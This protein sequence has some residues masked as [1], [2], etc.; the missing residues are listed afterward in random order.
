MFDKAQLLGIMTVI[1]HMFHSHA[2]SAQEKRWNDSVEKLAHALQSGKKLT[3]E[4]A[5]IMLDAVPRPQEVFDSF[6]ENIKEDITE[7]IKTSIK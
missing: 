2:E 3:E 7:Q 4:Q 1:G 5:W 6:L